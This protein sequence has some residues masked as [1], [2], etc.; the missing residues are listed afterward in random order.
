MKPALR[1]ASE[2]TEQS[3]G[4]LQPRALR[5][6]AVTLPSSL[7]ELDELNIDKPKL[8][9]PL[10]ERPVPRQLTRTKP[11]VQVRAAAPR[12][13]R[14]AETPALRSGSRFCGLGSK[15]LGCRLTTPNVRELT[16]L[17][18]STDQG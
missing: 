13:K 9:P 17:A 15:L 1:R 8:P 5:V 11:W 14:G 18:R 7:S 2:E 3:N 16:A 10:P 6:R 4:Y 12:L